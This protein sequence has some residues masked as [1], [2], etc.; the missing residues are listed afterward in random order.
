MEKTVKDEMAVGLQP[1]TMGV[2]APARVGPLSAI[3]AAL[4]FL[5]HPRARDRTV[6][7]ASAEPGRTERPERDRSAYR[8]PVEAGI[9]GGFSLLMGSPNASKRR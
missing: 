2:R 4:H 9:T 1:E 3:A 5:T 6:A 8:S 7:E